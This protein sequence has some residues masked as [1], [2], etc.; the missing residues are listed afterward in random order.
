VAVK[1]VMLA[2]AL[3]LAGCQAN[4]TGNRALDP[5]GQTVQIRLEGVAARQ[6]VRGELRFEFFASKLVLDERSGEL[7]ARGGV[8]GRLEPGLWK[9]D[10][11]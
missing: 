1:W 6:Y 2:T 9:R 7:L 11:P 5:A 3:A 4:P 8:R 10:D